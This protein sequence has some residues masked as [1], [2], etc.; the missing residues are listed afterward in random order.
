MYRKHM[1]WY[2]G[3]VAVVCTLAMPS[4]LAQEKFPSRPIEII[5]PTAAGGG[6]DIAFRML[7]EIAEPTLGQ[8]VVVSNKVGG[9]GMIGMT[10]IVR[11][12]PDGYTLGG[13]WNAPL[14]MTP[15]MQP[16]PYS[17]NDYATVTLADS[18][19][20]IFCTKADFPANSGK[21]FI[22][23]LKANPG[24]FT[25]GNDGVGGTLHL[26]AERIFSKVGVK[27]RP[28]P[29]TGAGET[30]KN[31][32]GGHIDIYA[33]SITPIL[34]YLKDGQAKCLLVTTAKR[35]ATIPQ[36]ASLTDIGVPEAQ[37]VLWHGLIA[38]NGVPAD[39]MA[40]LENAFR[41]AARSDR[42]RQYMES[43]GIEVEASSA[44]EFR[45]LIDTEYVAM[46]E[47]MKSL[48]LAKQ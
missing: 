33:G 13:L 29:F 42:F 4:A 11:A 37:T 24:K 18:A 23:Y 26:A 40:V 48:G 25:Y 45:K 5:V 12:K 14:T 35:V 44:A 30:L 47:V 31:F 21:E 15:H 43:R 22:E 27:A 36:A 2:C 17:P 19:A 32:L 41:Q 38:P 28:V 6:T 20:T 16:A 46:G 10:A 1:S 7:A 3:I 34:P 39:R 9:G 8:K